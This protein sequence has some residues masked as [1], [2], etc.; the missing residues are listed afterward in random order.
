MNIRPIK[1]ETDYRAALKEIEQLMDAKPNTA[2]GNR[3]EV[4]VT[5]VEHYEESRYP[6]PAPDPIEAIRYYMESRGLTRKDLEP[7]IGDRARVQAVL[8]RKR[9]LSIAMIRKL[10]SGLGISA[11]VLIQPYHARAA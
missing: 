11:D 6:I 8:A 2:T 3:L 10:N 4:L 7:Y 1:T 9:P 5:L